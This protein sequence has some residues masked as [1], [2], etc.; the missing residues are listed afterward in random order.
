MGCFVSK[1]DKGSRYAVGGETEDGGDAAPAR[2]QSS[3]KSEA[4]TEPLVAKPKLD[5]KDFI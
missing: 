5:P 3:S 4:K 1:E 2:S